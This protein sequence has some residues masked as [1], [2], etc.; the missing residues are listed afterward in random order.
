MSTTHVLDL[1]IIGAGP[2]GVISL[3]Y[4]IEAGVD[5]LV[6][7]KQSR[8]GGLWAWLPSWQDIQYNRLDW[9]LGDLPIAGEN[10]ESIR[11]NIEAWVD[12]FGLS[13]RIRLNC[14]ASRVRHDGQHW[15]VSTLQGEHRARYLIAA[16]GVHNRAAVPPVERRHTR[17]REF[18]SSAL[19]NPAE[20]AGQR[21]VVVGGGASAYDLLDL[22][23]EH[24]ARTVVWIYRGLRWMAPTRKPKNAAGG[25]RDLGRM[26]ALGLSLEVI[27]QLTN[28]SLSQRYEKLGLTEIMPERSFDFARDQM[29]PGRHRMINGYARIERH[30]GE[31]TAIDGQVV[32]L[33][34]GTEVGA[35][36]L[37]WGTGY[38]ADT[39]YF[40]SPVLSRTWARSELAKRCGSMF[41]SLDAPNLFFLAPS[42]LESTGTVPLAYAYICRSIIAHVQ[43][44]AQFGTQRVDGYRNYFDLLQVLAQAD[45]DH[46]P[47]GWQESV[48]KLALEY[49]DEL[50]L[51]IP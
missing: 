49:P 17:V 14:E 44:K 20:L 25:P 22:C 16:T 27:N 10:Q 9:T 2:G 1:L 50:P 24:G 36:L 35:D 37:L 3:K 29:I 28:E 48:R 18:H 38:E 21:V 43:G 13:S 23:F 31:V 32:R 12:R 4:A 8:V 30:R 51:P 6:I 11:A 45:P 42:L 26:Q 7:E 40:E 19:S 34:D 39:R 15:L 41:L 33:S 5:A 47:V 46:F